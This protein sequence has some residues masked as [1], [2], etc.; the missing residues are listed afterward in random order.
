VFDTITI[1]KLYDATDIEIGG[2]NYISNL[3]EN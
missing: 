1:V 3:E 2:R